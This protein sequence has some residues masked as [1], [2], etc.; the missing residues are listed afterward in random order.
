MYQELLT[1]A[2][3]AAAAGAAIL[4]KNANS[5]SAADI[6][7]KGIH[8]FVTRVDKAS[9]EAIIKIIRANHPDHSIL[10]EE[11]GYHQQ[12]SPFRWV[13]DPLDGTTNFIHGYKSYCVSVAVE[14]AGQMVAGVV[15]DPTRDEIFS[16]ARGDGAFLNG[17]KFSVSQVKT[18]DRSLILTGFPFKAAHM[19][20][21]FISVFRKLLPATS[22]I[23]RAGSAALDLSH[24]ACG[25]ADG[26]WEFGLSAWDIA[27]G[28]LLVEE[29][30]GIIA[31]IEGGADFLKTGNVL[32]GNPEIFIA[33]K[34]MLEEMFP[35]GHFRK[36]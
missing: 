16:A 5:L 1:T 15:N 9:E 20:D 10:A 4:K 19:M 21:D 32:C 34:T 8:D 28:A 30:G 35:K 26:Y 29:A 14:K 23:R 7:E 22:G 18:L 31:D 36:E 12:Q 27:A 17:E 6:D 24:I 33:I 25:R 13:I 11:S 2:L 3:Q